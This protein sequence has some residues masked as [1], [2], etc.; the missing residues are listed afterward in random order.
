MKI[1]APNSKLFELYG[2]QIVNF[3]NFCL[4][5]LPV[6]KIPLGMFFDSKNSKMISK[7]P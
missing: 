6:L 1:L 7:L 4:K 2:G 5:Q 3:L